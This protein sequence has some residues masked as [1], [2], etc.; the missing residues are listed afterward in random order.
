MV[1]FVVG[2]I[3]ISTTKLWRKGR[4]SSTIRFLEETTLIIEYYL[5]VKRTLIY[6]YA[7]VN[8]FY[9]TVVSQSYLSLFPT[10]PRSLNTLCF[11]SF[12][13]LQYTS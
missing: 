6:I 9:Y 8:H 10:P 1:T 4:S 13:H 12:L 5:L 2:E 7:E 11:I 3:N